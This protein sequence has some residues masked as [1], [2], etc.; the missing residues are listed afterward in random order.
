MSKIT[1]ALEKAARERLQ[2]AGEKPTV[3]AGAVVV[4]VLPA[5]PAAE[6]L[7]DRLGEITAVGQVTIDPHI[8]TATDPNSPIA[9]QYRILRTNFQSLRLKPGVK[10]IVVTS[11]IHG[12]GKSVT[13]INL[14]MSLARQEK[15]RVA[16]VDADMRK[17]SVPRWL[18]LAVDGQGLSTT[19][20]RD[21]ELDGSLVRFQSPPLTV[22]PAGPAPSQPAELLESLALK[23]VLATLRAQF[24]YVVIDAPP[25]LPVADAGILAAQAD[26]VIL[27]VRAGKTQ[28]R[29]VL[30]AHEH[31]K[32]MKAKLLGCVLTHMEYYLP[33]HKQYYRYQ[34]AAA[35]GNG[36]PDGS[37]DGAASAAA[38]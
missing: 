22:L 19:L 10:V 11:A 30:Q 16:L 3:A 20:E 34:R 36:K 29:P 25:V 17:G 26:G 38:A 28:R 9:E 2:R 33:G 14:A 1:R 8:V 35:E 27:V 21:G 24:D 32:K 23:R 31:V 37:A 15:L 12:E 5:L 4:P 13:S 18:G 6:P 7:P